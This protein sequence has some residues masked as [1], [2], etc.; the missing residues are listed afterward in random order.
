M[1]RIEQL[2]ALI[3][4][5]L[6]A[7]ASTDARGQASESPSKGAAT[8]D[9]SGG[10]PTKIP[11]AVAPGWRWAWYRPYVIVSA[12][13]DGGTVSTVHVPYGA[14]PTVVVIQPAGRPAAPAPPRGLIPDPVDRRAADRARRAESEAIAM[15][16]RMFRAG[17][18]KRAED[19][20]RRAAR[21]A[22][23]SATPPMRLA[24]VA[25]ARGRYATAAALLRDAEAAEPGWL[26]AAKDV[27]TL[28]RDPADHARDLDALAEFVRTN[29]EDRDAALVL[30]AQLFLIRREAQAADVFRQLDDPRHKVDLALAAFLRATGVRE[31]EPLPMPSRPGPDGDPFQPPP[32][33]DA[34]RP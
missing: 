19:R 1:T 23:S 4:A 2:G 14:T 30:G 9:D 24:Q 32:A 17:D 15:G 5:G 18:H 22:P 11:A 26:A 29:P 20:Y 21:L 7:I 34:P 31:V 13:P 25:V 10:D 28:Y 33:Q 16:D 12:T 27:M 3:S 8:S 6:I